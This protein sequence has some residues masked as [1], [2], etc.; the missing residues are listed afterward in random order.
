MK[1]VDIRV[2]GKTEIDMNTLTESAYVK[3]DKLFNEYSQ[4]RDYKNYL[5]RYNKYEFNS[6]INSFEGRND[7]ELDE[8]WFK[9]DRIELEIQILARDYKSYKG[10]SIR[11]VWDYISYGIGHKYYNVFLF[12]TFFG[13]G[14]DYS[15]KGDMTRLIACIV[16]CG[17]NAYRFLDKHLKLDYKEV[18]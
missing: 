14:L 13:L 15:A 10:F 2:I 11:K 5:W 1:K 4:L 8:T 9:L 6:E 16:V 12:T 18:K 3:I 17:I 7:R